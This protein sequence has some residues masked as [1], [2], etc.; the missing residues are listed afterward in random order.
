MCL[1]QPDPRRLASAPGCRS[2]GGAATGVDAGVATGWDD[3][4]Q[5][6]IS[7]PVPLSGYAAPWQLHTTTAVTLA[8][9][10]ARREAS[11]H[12]SASPTTLE[13]K[14]RPEANVLGVRW[15]M[16]FCDAPY[17]LRADTG[18]GVTPE[19]GGDAEQSSRNRSLASGRD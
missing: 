8:S 4:Q 14:P 3:W 5:R 18:V 6:G 9:A 7:R 17:C 1:R 2:R 12:P 16:G 13:P 15:A 10:S 19:I 11:A